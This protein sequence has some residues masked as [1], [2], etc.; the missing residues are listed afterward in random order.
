[1]YKHNFIFAI[2]KYE[3]IRNEI[4]YIELYLSTF[5][6]YVSYLSSQ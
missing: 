4:K 5:T 2:Q 1:M 3:L 6:K